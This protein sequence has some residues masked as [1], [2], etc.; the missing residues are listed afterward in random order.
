[1][2]T[3]IPGDA[4][5]VTLSQIEV[6][7]AHARRMHEALHAQ[8]MEPLYNTRR[9]LAIIGLSTLLLEAIEEVRVIS[10]ALREQS[11]TAR[12]LSCA[13]RTLRAAPATRAPA[14]KTLSSGL[15]NCRA[16]RTVITAGRQ[17]DRL[18]QITVRRETASMFNSFS[19]S[20]SAAGSRA[21]RVATHTAARESLLLCGVAHPPQSAQPR[22]R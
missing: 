2:P 17:D 15:P 13:P 16:G 12:P 21:C 1:M 20:T 4:P 11:A 18:A 14:Q 3:S 7:I 6:W 9:D 22:S 5:A 10:T 8:A 19:A